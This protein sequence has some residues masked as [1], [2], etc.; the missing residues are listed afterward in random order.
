MRTNQR[1]YADIDL[2]AIGHNIDQVKGKIPEGVKVMAVI[3]A[4]AYGHG[5]VQ[6]GK[7]LENQV[8]Y[9]GVATI[10]EAVE[11][12]KS[13]L[14][15]PILI[16]GY[17]LKEQYKN[18]VSYGIT[19]TIYSYQAACALNEEAQKQQKKAVVHIALDTGMT[20]IGFQTEEESI[21][22]I[23]KIKELPWLEVEGIFSHF[24]CA[25]EKDKTYANMQ[26]EKYDSFLDR[27][28]EAGVEIPIKHLC[29]SA[30]IMEFDHH[31]YQMVRSG[32]IT[33]GLY[34]SEEVDKTALD[35]Q[36]ALTWKSHVAHVKTVKAGLGVSYGATFIT[37]ENMKI[38]TVL[39]GYAD[40]YPRSLSN[41]G[42][43]LIHGKSVPIIGRVCMDQV[44]IDVTDVENVQVEDEVTL[45]GRD[46]DEVIP[47][48]ELAAM[49]YSFNY[50]FVCDINK[51]VI[52][53][54]LK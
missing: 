9:F 31:R 30:G 4:D 16:L 13:G 51:R 43:M 24:S 46:G 22:E 37:R 40:G 3:K 12:R 23:Q 48:E 28:E 39:V 44:M 34:P 8:D 6:V 2:R 7:Y 32:I 27:L 10:E 52:R 45:V 54:Y 11:L 53:N 25:D 35:L 5:A 15:L 41:K 47:V 42:R 33:Y 1:C 36:P 49:S 19:Q 50:E 18:V 29:N 21:G 38:A 20:R 26:M 14:Q 17:T